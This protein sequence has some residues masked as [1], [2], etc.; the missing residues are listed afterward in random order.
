MFNFGRFT[1]ML[2]CTRLVCWWV[3]NNQFVCW[4]CYLPSVCCWIVS[5]FIVLFCVNRPTC[6]PEKY[7]KKC[8]KHAWSVD[9]VFMYCFHSSVCVNLL[10]W[11]PSRWSVV[12]KTRKQVESRSH[13]CLKMWKRSYLSLQGTIVDKWFQGSSG[14]SCFIFKSLW[15]VM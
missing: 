8:S 9:I 5:M 6:L 15:K 2:K 12:C 1:S 11:P 13:H 3:H 14:G 7:L 4:I 10:K